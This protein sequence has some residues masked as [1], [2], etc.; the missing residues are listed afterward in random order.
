[1]CFR[2][3]R[4]PKLAACG[5]EPRGSWYVPV[6]GY[7]LSD[8]AT[9]SCP[10]AG[11]WRIRVYRTRFLSSHETDPRLQLRTALADSH[12]P[13]DVVCHAPCQVDVARA[14]NL[15]ANQAG[16]ERPALYDLQ[17]SHDDLQL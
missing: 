5:Y 6:S 8:A 7:R 3:P 16:M 15:L 10:T 1:L 4:S 2:P 14:G 13:V 11:T 17:N 12:G 9:H